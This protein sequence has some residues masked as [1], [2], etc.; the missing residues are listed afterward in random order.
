MVMCEEG[1]DGDM[2][3][4]GHKGKGS[5][6]ATEGEG[7]GEESSRMIGRTLPERLMGI[8]VWSLTNRYFTNLF[9]WE[10]RNRW[11]NINI[12]AENLEEWQGRGRRTKTG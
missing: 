8:F 2:T 11:G 1:R 7:S 4:R 9:A 6:W 3:E 5:P 12:M 10:K